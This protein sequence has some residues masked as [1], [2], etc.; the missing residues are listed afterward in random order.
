MIIAFGGHA[1]WRIKSV[2][3]IRVTENVQRRAVTCHQAVFTVKKIIFQLPVKGKEQTSEG[4]VLKLV[5]L[6]VKSRLGRRIGAAAKISVNLPADAF[7][8]HGE[9]HED[10]A[11]KAKLPVAGEIPAGPFGVFFRIRRQIINGG[12]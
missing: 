11:L 4:P 12:K 1:A 5:Q 8:F 3:V 9:E 2:R 6:P 10:E 7:P